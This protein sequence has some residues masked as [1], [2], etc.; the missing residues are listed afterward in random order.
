MEIGHSHRINAFIII[1]FNSYF[2]DMSSLDSF[3]STNVEVVAPA[4]GR[5]SP[6]QGK[7]F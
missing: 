3:F 4:T 7:G 6:T 5:A 1:T 2:H